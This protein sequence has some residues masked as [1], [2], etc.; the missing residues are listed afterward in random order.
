M[1]TTPKTLPS[2]ARRAVLAVA[3]LGGLAAAS[4][5]APTEPDSGLRSRLYVGLAVAALDFDDAYKGLKLADSSAGIGVYGGLRLRD[6]LS[7]ELSYDA[8]DAIDL[9]DVAGSG[10]VRL[11]IETERRTTALSVLREISFKELFDWRR[12]WR[13]Y[14]TVGV[15]DSE[16]RRTITMLGS[17]ARTSADDGDTGLLL[18]AGVLYGVG[19]VELRG[20]V[21]RG[22]DAREAGAAV[23]FKF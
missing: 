17:N 9:H 22:G 20:Y 16:L 4:S 18:G 19:R 8:F 14:G 3:A 21:L 23:Q 5:A 2:H 15:Y 11:D 10:I 7:L 13:V 6:R 12:D 1:R